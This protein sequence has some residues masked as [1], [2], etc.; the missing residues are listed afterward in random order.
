[1]LGLVLLAATLALAGCAG[2]PAPAPTPT[3]PVVSGGSQTQDPSA[4]GAPSPSATPAGPPTCA[5]IIPADTV[6]AFTEAGWTSREDPFYVGNIE[7][8]D[9]IQCTWGNAKI[10]SD[11]VQVF[12]WAPLDADQARA[13]KEELLGS[14]WKEFEE[15]GAVYLTATGDMVMNPDDD[16][17]GMTYRLDDGQIT[18]ADTRQGLLLIQWPPAG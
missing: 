6:D 7:L 10:A 12:G 18:L 14:G 11:Q 5:G 13:V 9:G 3:G 16:G 4:T 17:Y 1:M 15:N 2:S 8:P